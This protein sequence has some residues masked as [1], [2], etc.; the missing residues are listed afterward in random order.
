M[1]KCFDETTVKEYFVH[2]TKWH[3]VRSLSWF[4]PLKHT[5]GDL[6]FFLSSPALQLTARRDALQSQLT[7]DLTEARDTATR[8]SWVANNVPLTK[9]LSHSSIASSSSHAHQLLS[10]NFNSLSLPL[11]LQTASNVT[12]AHA[13]LGR[14][15]AQM[16][17]SKMIAPA[18]RPLDDIS[19]LDEPFRF[20][21]QPDAYEIDYIKIECT[22]STGLTGFHIHGHRRFH[23]AS[24]FELFIFKCS[25]GADVKIKRIEGDGSWWL[26]WA[27]AR[28]CRGRCF[29]FSWSG[30]VRWWSGLQNWYQLKGTIVP[31][32]TVGTNIHTVAINGQMLVLEKYSQAEQSIHQTLPSTGTQKEAIH[33]QWHELPTHCSSCRSCVFA[34]VRSWR[35]KWPQRLMISNHPVAYCN[36]DDTWLTCCGSPNPSL[37]RQSH[38]MIMWYLQVHPTNHRSPL[39]HGHLKQPFSLSHHVINRFSSIDRSLERVWTALSLPH[40]MEVALE[41]SFD[42]IDL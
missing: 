4:W 34:N 30:T 9:W 16:N 31:S 20:N 42:E 21:D 2:H 5:A 11:S 13:S 24:Q 28:V 40:A 25:R 33:E 32:I 8:S 23:F 39:P 38:Q 19:P 18:K 27:V 7:H 12:D 22:E 17:G 36:T 10:N 35:L 26:Y 14:C 41:E 15:E 6:F 29:I 3:S 1:G 37:N